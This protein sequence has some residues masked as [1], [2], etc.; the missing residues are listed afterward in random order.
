MTFVNVLSA[1]LFGLAGAGAYLII[2]NR[3]LLQ[4]K[5]SLPKSGLVVATAI[6]LPCG[7]ALFGLYSGW[8]VWL[9]LPIL[10][11]LG[12][13]A[14]EVHR[15]RLR[16]HHRGTPPVEVQHVQTSLKRP[17]THLDLSVIRYELPL[18]HWQSPSL[19]IAHI[20]DLHVS[21][22]YP[23]AFYQT[24]LT[25]LNDAQP[26]LVVITGD[27]VVS[28]ASLALL[29]DVLTPLSNR[30]PTFAIL[31]NH[32]YWVDAAAVT[33]ILRTCDIHLLGKACHPIT[34]NG[35][36]LWL[37]GD[38]APWGPA[39]K[40]LPAD[41]PEVVRI[42]LSHTPDNIYRLSAMGTALVF[43]GHYHAGQIRLPYF[44]SLVV[45]SWYGR[46][47]DHGHFVVKGTHLFVSA[48]IG[49]ISVPLRLYC[50]PDIVLVDLIPAG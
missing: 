9:L 15:A 7:S 49:S 44:G 46:R 8:S 30:H 33:A 22:R 45:P 28:A 27:F 47:F 32:D 2:L 18:A 23:A 6:L 11:V 10:I 36:T 1:L 31:G 24:L 35:N 29:P 4:I 34:R 42:V 12:I 14:G 38:E 13:A 37:C 16:T 21:P 48:G 17:I 3:L 20:S 40:D 19:R 39:L 41:A 26:D 25:R 43:A 5:D 50:Q